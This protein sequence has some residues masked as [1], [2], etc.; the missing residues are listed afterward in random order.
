MPRL[1]RTQCGLLQNIVFFLDK[2]LPAGACTIRTLVNLEE[3]ALAS[4][5]HSEPSA[6]PARSIRLSSSEPSPS[7]SPAVEKA[8]P[9]LPLRRRGT[10]DCFLRSNERTTRAVARIGARTIY[11]SNWHSETDSQRNT[12]S[13]NW[14]LRV[15]GQFLGRGRSRGTPEKNGP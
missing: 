1:L 4:Q 10:L 9:S 7:A 2:F 12:T 3:L 15:L 13:K 8:R 14:A 11:M 6:D 5:D